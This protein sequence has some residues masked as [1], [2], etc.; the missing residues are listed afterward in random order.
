MFFLSKYYISCI[1]MNIRNYSSLVRATKLYLSFR[2]IY[3]L[4][5][6][7][8]SLIVLLC[9]HYFHFIHY[10]SKYSLILKTNFF[11][12]LFVCKILLF[13]K[14]VVKACFQPCHLL[15]ISTKQTLINV[16]PYN[17]TSRMNCKLQVDFFWFDLIDLG[18]IHKISFWLDSIK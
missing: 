4:I 12:I 2:S 14:G 17:R 9:H 16:N 7:V 11:V 18:N 3:A 5:I 13:F 10:F 1:L 8:H 15:T 6:V